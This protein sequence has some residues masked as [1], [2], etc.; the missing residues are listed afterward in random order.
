MTVAMAARAESLCDMQIVM[1]TLEAHHYGSG[2]PGTPID[3]A[4]L[5]IQPTDIQSDCGYY[6]GQFSPLGN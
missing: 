2:K 6:A 3:N 4:H 5:G 1:Q